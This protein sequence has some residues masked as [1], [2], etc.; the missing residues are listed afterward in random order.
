MQNVYWPSGSMVMVTMYDDFNEKTG[1]YEV[2]DFSH[3]S[4]TIVDVDLQQ[5]LPERLAEKVAEQ[6]TESYN[7]GLEHAS[8]HQEAYNGS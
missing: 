1:T 2:C 8:P 5:V 3:L 4:S 7:W 6:M